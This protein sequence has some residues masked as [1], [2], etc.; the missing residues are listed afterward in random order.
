MTEAVQLLILGLT[1]GG[2]YALMASG[3]T[4]VF[5]VMHIVNLAHAVIMFLGAYLTWGAFTVAGIDPLLSL[6]L[7]MPV[8]FGFGVAIYRLLFWRL[9]GRHRFVQA[10]VLLTFSLALVIEGTLAFAFTG[11]YRT[12]TP[13]YATD[14]FIVGEFFVPTAQLYAS[15]VSVLLLGLLGAVLYF[16]R[17]GSAI[18]ATMQNRTAAQIVGVNVR[19]TSSIA[20]GIGLALAGASGA[21]VSFLFTF[22]PSGH[23]QWIALLLSVIVLGGLGSLRGALV[24][25]VSLGVISVFVGNWFGSTWQP[26]TFYLALFVVLMVRP[27]GLFGQPLEAR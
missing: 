10:T 15:L 11:I 20:F 7:T 9:E 8:M 4:L 3:L 12:T 25:A 13:S 19:R 14:A 2:V 18:R 17:T 23:W 16:T 1:L 26:M 27:E 22:F 5:G 6:L 24:G 21:M